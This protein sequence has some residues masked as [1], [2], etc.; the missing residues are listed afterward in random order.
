M[1]NALA[2]N[3]DAWQQSCAGRAKN[4]LVLLRVTDAILTNRL[5]P[6]S[7]TKSLI[8]SFAD[9]LCLL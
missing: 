2:T 1:P 9:P 6:L 3:L 4:V 5:S 7:N 8:F